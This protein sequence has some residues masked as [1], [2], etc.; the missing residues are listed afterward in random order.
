MFN[1]NNITTFNNVQTIPCNN[2]LPI[3][4]NILQQFMNFKV[5]KLTI[6]ARSEK[7]NNIEESVMIR[8][9]EGVQRVTSPK[10]I[11]W[12]WQEWMRVKRCGTAQVM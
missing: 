3:A 1:N 5:G 10:S 7:E 4:R 6:G 8:M 12:F 9:D 11:N 2:K